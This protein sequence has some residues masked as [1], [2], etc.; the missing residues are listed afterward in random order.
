MVEETKN[1]RE[2]EKRVRAREREM[3]LCLRYLLILN[4]RRISSF[5]ENTES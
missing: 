1:A 4:I 3:E 2:E 5:L